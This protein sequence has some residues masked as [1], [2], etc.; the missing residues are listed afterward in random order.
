MLRV[1]LVCPRNLVF[2]ILIIF[3]T[4][5]SERNR[6][7][8]LFHA[9][10]FGYERDCVWRRIVQ[11]F[12]SNI[13]VQEDKWTTSVLR[14]P[15][16]LN[17]MHSERDWL[18]KM[19]FSTVKIISTEADSHIC[20]CYSTNNNLS[21]AGAATSIIF[22][23]TNRSFVATKHVFC[24]HKS[25]LFATKLL[26]WQNYVCRDKPFVATNIKHMFVATSILL[27]RQKTCLSRQKYACVCRDKSML[28]AT[29]IKRT[30]FV[31][32]MIIIKTFMVK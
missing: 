12:H 5:L 27:S 22:V 31:A 23:A 15:S 24:R 30:C 10:T 3:E 13:S 16:H 29:I 8:S 18:I 2:F 32:P 20:R 9:R 21:L 4:N 26:S 25:M 7:V 19:Y 6:F 14:F 11:K 28:V 17:E 1:K